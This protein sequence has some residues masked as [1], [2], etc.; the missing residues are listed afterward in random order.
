MI[1]W[2]EKFR[3]YME[4]KKI[5]WTQTI[6][7]IVFGMVITFGA[8]MY[9]IYFSKSE[10]LKA[11]N[12]RLTKVKENLVGIIEEHVV[13]KDSIDLK[14]LERLIINRTKEE[15]LSVRLTIFDLLTQA[16][17]NIKNSKHLSFE[18]KQEYARVISHLHLQLSHDTTVMLYNE[19]NSQ[20][21]YYPKINDSLITKI[22]SI[23][24]AAKIDSITIAIKNT[25]F[26]ISQK[27]KI[28]TESILQFLLDSPSTIIMISSA[29]LAL[30]AMYLYFM[31]IRK[32]R[33][34]RRKMLE[35][36]INKIETMLATDEDISEKEKTLLKQ[37]LEMLH[38]EWSK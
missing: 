15:N 13:N 28:K 32:K 3:K 35:R 4:K 30:I 37:Y 5:N 27:E 12:E 25:Y 29:Y 14:S 23:K 11:E 38:W 16:E 10:L 26:E 31:S 21:K 20:I 33:S 9:T 8:T 24:I 17:Y 18:K 6:V 7:S 34:K 2:I 36:D 1:K 19:K 22:D